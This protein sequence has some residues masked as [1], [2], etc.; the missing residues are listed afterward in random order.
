MQARS[1][2]VVASTMCV[3]SSGRIHF[4]FAI[5]QRRV[6][7]HF[8]Q[9]DLQPASMNPHVVEYELNFHDMQGLPFRVTA[10]FALGVGV[11]LEFKPDAANAA[12]S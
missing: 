11:C 2:L 3:L 6:E 5:A 8:R 1:S 10:L 9:K 7:H 4:G 12:C